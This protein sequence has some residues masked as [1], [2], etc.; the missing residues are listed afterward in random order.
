MP[1]LAVAMSSIVALPA[2]EEVGRCRHSPPDEA[3]HESISTHG[4]FNSCSTERCGAT[5]GGRQRKGSGSAG[6]QRPQSEA[7]A[8]LRC[9]FTQS[10][11]RRELGGTEDGSRWQGRKPIRARAL[12]DCHTQ[13]GGASRKPEFV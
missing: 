7:C 12:F 9:R 2:R 3:C 6:R 11:E 5:S 1:S 8:V 10:G 4:S 13:A